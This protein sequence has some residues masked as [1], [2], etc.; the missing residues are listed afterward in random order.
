MTWVRAVCV[1]VTCALVLAGCQEEQRQVAAVSPQEPGPD[2][3]GYYCGMIVTN[4]T[5]PKGQIFLK[6]RE[7]PLWFSSVREAL[8]FTMLPEEPKAIAA[9]FVN[10]MG[11]AGSWDRPE[12]GFWVEARSAIYVAGSGRRGGMR[13]AEVV[14]FGD[15][16]AAERFRA[17]HG[18]TIYAF[19]EVPDRYVLGAG[20]D[21]SG[22]GDA[23]R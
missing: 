5:G 21:G 22:A 6:G 13:A 18:G 20:S 4:H 10:D 1:A 14:P 3:V 15:R 12:P 23:E 7:Q 2:A 11:R 19:T 9:I 16:A 8:S 17:E